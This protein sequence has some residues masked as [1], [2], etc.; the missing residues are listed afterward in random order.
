MRNI[1]DNFYLY[2]GDDGEFI[3]LESYELSRKNLM[4]MEEYGMKL[5]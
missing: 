2:L 4:R 1:K 3:T 5:M